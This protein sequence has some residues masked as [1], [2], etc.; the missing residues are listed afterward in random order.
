MHEIPFDVVPVH[1]FSEVSPDS[2]SVTLNAAAVG[3]RLKSE[4]VRIEVTTYDP[5]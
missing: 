3:T 1:R 2:R 4:T 5:S